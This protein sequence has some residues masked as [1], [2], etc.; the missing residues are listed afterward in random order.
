[1]GDV[2]HPAACEAIVE[3]ITET[4]GP[5]DY[6]V[7]NVGVRR[8]G[9]PK[10]SPLR[11]IPRAGTV[12]EIADA[13]SFVALDQASYLTGQSLFVDGGMIMR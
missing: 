8:F 13:C 2:A 11:M 5:I 6:L 9:F 7:S 3:P 12:E 4:L 10:G 1:M